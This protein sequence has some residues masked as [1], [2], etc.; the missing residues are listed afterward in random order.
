MPSPEQA[1]RSVATLQPG[2]FFPVAGLA[3]SI[4]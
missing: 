2:N 3:E 4:R 1:E